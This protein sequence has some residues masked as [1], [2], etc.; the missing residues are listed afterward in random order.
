MS[1]PIFDITNNVSAALTLIGT[2]DA[3]LEHTRPVLLAVADRLSRQLGATCVPAAP[4]RL[5]AG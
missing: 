4:M 5:V 3:N 2:Q 1:A